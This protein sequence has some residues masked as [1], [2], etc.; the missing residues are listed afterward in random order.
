MLDVFFVS[1]P[2]I[3]PQITSEAY[4]DATGM[5]VSLSKYYGDYLW[6]DYAAEWCGYCTSQ[7]STIKSLEQ[8]YADKLVFLTVVAGTDKVMDPPTADTAMNWARRFNLNPT[9]VLA[10]F[11]TNTL[12]YHI[13]YSPSGKILYQG[14]GLFNASQISNILS[15][16]TPLLN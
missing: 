11:S 8:N 10:Q 15:T 3:A 1:P 4:I 7:T 6:V 12:P 2:E 14:S 9:K 5:E 16:H 13:L